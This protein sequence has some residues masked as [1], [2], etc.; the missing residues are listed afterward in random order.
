EDDPDNTAARKGL[1]ETLYGRGRPDLAMEQIENAGPSEELDALAA[2]ISASKRPRAGAAYRFQKNSSDGEYQSVD[3]T[4]TIPLGYRTVVVPGYLWGV[5]TRQD[6]P[7]IRRDRFRVSL[8]HRFNETFQ[9]TAAPGVELNRFDPMVVPPAAEPVEDFDLFVWDVYVTV[10]P[11]DWLRLDAGSSRVTMPIPVPVYRRIDVTTENIGLDWRISHRVAT[12]WA[13]A[14]SSYSDGNARFAAAHRGEWSPPVRVPYR[15]FN[16][17]TLIEGVD[18]FNFKTEKTN[19]Y[20]NP[21]EYLQPYIGLRFITDAGRRVRLKVEGRFGAEWDSGVGWASVG[22]FDASL[23]VRVAGET[24]LVL[25]AYK[26]GS[27][28]TS[29]DGFRAEGAYATLDLN[30]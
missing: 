23:R 18:Y 30:W 20:F 24:H 6:L 2:R 26:S 17:I 8:E 12:F 10:T 27:R 5:L 29:P 16:E 13:T 28:V 1:A 15:Y 4:G 14:Y 19:G 11:R 21:S 25:G 3:L 22:S 7:D 9:L